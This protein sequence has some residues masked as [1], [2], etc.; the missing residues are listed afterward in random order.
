MT[1]STL[2]PGD[3]IGHWTILQDKQASRWRCRCVC[4][5][6]RDVRNDHL[7]NGLT[8]SCGCQVKGAWRKAPRTGLIAHHIAKVAADAEAHRLARESMTSQMT[9]NSRPPATDSQIR[10]N[11]PAM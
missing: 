2:K 5:F 11:A 9:A 1:T 4:G 10:K 3:T 7:V 6:I 8:K